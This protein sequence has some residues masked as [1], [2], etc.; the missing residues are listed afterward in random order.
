LI[1]H[2]FSVVA[3]KLTR[4]A[5][6]L[7]LM[8]ATYFIVVWLAAAAVLVCKWRNSDGLAR[9]QLRYVAIGMISA[10]VLSI[11][12]NLILPLTTGRSTYTWLGPIFG[13]IFIGI[14]AHAVIRHRA[15]DLRLFVHRGLAMAV[16]TCVSLAPVI[17]FAIAIWPRLSDH[18]GRDE[19][20][21][22]SCALIAASLLTPLT[23]D[24]ISR[25]LDTYLYRRRANYQR[26]LRRTSRY[27]TRLLDLNVVV[28]FI[29]EAATVVGVDAVTVYLRKDRRFIL[30]GT[31]SQYRDTDFLAPDTLPPLI[32][33]AL[34]QESD[35]LV[36]D[37]LENSDGGRQFAARELRTLGWSVLLP[38]LFDNAVIGAIVVGPKLS[39]DPFYLQDVDLLMTLANQAGTAIKNA[40]LYTEAVLANEYVENI[41]S[42]IE[43]GVIAI[44]AAGQ[45]ALFNRAAQQLTGLEA[46]RGRDRAVSVLPEPLATLLTQTLGDGERRTQPDIELTADGTTKPVLCT[47]SALRDPAG[48]L[49]GAV[50]VFSD[51]TP[52]KE[53]EDQ[54]RRAE[55]LAYFE[56]LA[57]SL[58][59]EI[60]NPLVAIK[61]FTQLIPRRREDDRFIDEFTRIAS[62][63]IERMERLLRRLRT[64]SRPSTR[65]KQ[66]IDLRSP[67]RDAVEFI[68]PAFEEK[69]VALHASLGS[70]STAIFGDHAE[71]E[72]LFL[73]LLIN[74]RDA[75]PP[76]GAVTVELA[77]VGG[78]ARVVVSDNGSGVP[79]EVIGRI[80]DPFFTTKQGGVG[81]GLTICAGIATSHHANLR[82][83]NSQAGGAT[84]IFEVPLA[85]ALTTPAPLG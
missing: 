61:T 54:R 30:A 33:S 49:L 15:M 40:Q 65:P 52:L 20:I 35:A 82:A 11:V 32:V 29:A 83:A 78:A 77:E 60:K 31:R 63:E 70:R 64:L 45:I 79:T 55:R 74:G 46:V 39:G 66:H 25:L 5:G 50:A 18:F 58:A 14:T 47:T 84:F 43:S 37:E 85:P 28:S 9:A 26:T 56:V 24:G 8:F 13:L 16:A 44:D 22:A 27:L 67:I 75:T 71:L 12:T 80:F 51:L 7:Y 19:L 21:G 48:K 34:T 42:T 57:S 53:L 68:R 59:H 76:G 36:R 23:R 62:R 73:N 2:D 72:E 41:V 10:N 38:I 69:R 81:L 4:T 6:P 17:A 1:A 3:G